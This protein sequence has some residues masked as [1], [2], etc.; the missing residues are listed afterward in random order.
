LNND[1]FSGSGGGGILSGL[2]RLKIQRGRIEY[3]PVAGCFG[4]VVPEGI[5]LGPVQ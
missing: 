1:G 2:I 5:D 3:K 4:H